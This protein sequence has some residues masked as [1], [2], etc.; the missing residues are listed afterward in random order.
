M[1]SQLILFLQNLHNLLS[2][3]SQV[4]DLKGNFNEQGT[5]KPSVIGLSDIIIAIPGAV[6]RTINQMFVTMAG[7]IVMMPMI[8]A[9]HPSGPLGW[10]SG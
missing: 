1:S 4:S 3:S 8:L 9:A 2:A 6:V 10:L 7:A 5:I